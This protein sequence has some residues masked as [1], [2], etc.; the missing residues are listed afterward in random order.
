M[1]GWLAGC[2]KTLFEQNTL[3]YCT[4]YGSDFSS[5]S[6][7]VARAEQKGYLGQVGSYWGEIANTSDA[8]RNGNE[9]RLR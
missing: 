4:R 1:A 9:L 2:S 6:N 7:G 8:V 3:Q 5:C